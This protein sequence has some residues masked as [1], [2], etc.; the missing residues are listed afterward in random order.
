MAVK[1]ERRLRALEK[2]DTPPASII[3]MFDESYSDKEMDDAEQNAIGEWERRNG[4]I[5]NRNV[6]LFAVCSCWPGKFDG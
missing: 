3:Y 5:G 1:I 6:K 2:D 4:P